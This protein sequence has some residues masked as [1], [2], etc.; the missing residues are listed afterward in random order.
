MEK[1]IYLIT[2]TVNESVYI[3][4]G[5]IKER[6]QE[7]FRELR[8]NVHHNSHLQSSFNMYGE[9]SFIF[10]V[11][12]FLENRDELNNIE[13]SYIEKYREELGTTRVYNQ[14]DG[15]KGFSGYQYP[16]G[17][18]HWLY[19]KP[20]PE[21]TKEKLY[22]SN[23][24]KSRTQETKDKISVANKGKTMSQEAK[25]KMSKSAKL[26]KATDETKEKMRISQIG[27]VTSQETKDKLSN[28]LRNSSNIKRKGV[29]K[30]DSL[31]GEVIATFVSLRDA[32]ENTGISKGSI[33]NCCLGRRK[34]AGNFKW[35]HINNY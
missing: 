11:L 12:L 2:N 3:G 18:D 10:T 19:G 17:E 35:E 20:M 15:G 7:H 4:Q 29:Y 8:K 26:R 31:T 32:S 6:K 24:G 28:S 25:D 13:I 21:N 23:K 27:R 9:E 16:M 14:T 22:L 1:G 5:N 34:S 30:I 33:S